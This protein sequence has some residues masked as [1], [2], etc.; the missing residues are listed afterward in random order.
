M[1]EYAIFFAEYADF[2]ATNS[3]VTVSGKQFFTEYTKTKYCQLLMNQ[4]YNKHEILRVAIQQNK[5]SLKTFFKQVNVDRAEGS[6]AMPLLK[7]MLMQFSAHCNCGEEDIVVTALAA[8][9]I[10]QNDLL[11][12]GYATLLDSHGFLLEVVKIIFNLQA[13]HMNNKRLFILPFTG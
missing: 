4:I 6:K 8:S 12:N 7:H 2:F 13:S 1:D 3:S 10:L 11:L 5:K 9:E